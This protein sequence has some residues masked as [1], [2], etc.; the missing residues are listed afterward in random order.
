MCDA[1]HTF[2]FRRE[3]ERYYKHRRKAQ[4][5]P[6]FYI[7]I[8]VD[9]MDQSKTDLPHII[10]NP[11]ILAGCHTLTTHITGVKV[12]GRDT[13]MYIDYGTLSHDTNLTFTLLLQSIS[14][15]KVRGVM[16][17]NLMYVLYI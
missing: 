9:G 1:V 13:F 5:Y 14:K 11:K 12:H 7:S 6:D 10:S 15:Y 16:A 4:K 3:C 8:I 2:S 17:H